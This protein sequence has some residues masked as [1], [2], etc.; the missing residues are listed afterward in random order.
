MFKCKTG[1]C[2]VSHYFSL[3]SPYVNIVYILLQI[4]FYSSSLLIIN[5]V[6]K[7]V[8]GIV[9]TTQGLGQVGLVETPIAPSLKPRRFRCT[10]FI[11]DPSLMA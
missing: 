2:T 8:L 10:N 9:G 4:K 1:I 3:H 7:V 5:F 6:Q 11:V